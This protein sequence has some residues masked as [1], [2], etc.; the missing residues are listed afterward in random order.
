M[1]FPL[2]GLIAAGYTPFDADR[3]LNVGAVP[4]MADYFR[5]AGVNGVFVAGTTGESLSLSLAERI[6]LTSAWCDAAPPQIP[7]IVHVGSNSQ[8]EAVELASQAARA[9]AQGVAVMA[10]SFFKPSSIDELIGFCEPI[11]RAAADVP[12]YYYHIP[13]MTGVELHVAEFLKRAGQRMANLAGVKYSGSDLMDVQECLHAEGGRFDVLFGQDQNL[14]AALA[15]GLKGAIGSTYNY[16][17]GIY[18]RVIEAFE[19][20]D[21]EAARREQ[22]AS[23]SLVRLLSQFNVLVAGKE[24]MRL[25]GIDCGSVRAPLAPLDLHKTR[26]LYEALKPLDVFARP[27]SLDLVDV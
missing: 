7:V 8:P 1:Q 13:Q 10:P 20:G 23:V 27:L 12:F 22:A 14:L 21:I 2:T 16:A 25:M 4:A 19:S 17:P 5:E 24:I 3:R 15:L 26:E 6:E 9:G 18:Q 11:A